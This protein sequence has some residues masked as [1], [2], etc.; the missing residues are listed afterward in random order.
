MEYS[1]KTL[2]LGDLHLKNIPGVPGYIKAQVEAIKR[3]VW[4]ESPYYTVLLGDVFHSR[5]PTPTE[6]LRF[7][8][9]IRE[10]EAGT[11]IK[12]FVI[13]GNHDSETKADDGVTCLSLFASEKT[14]VA[15][16][17]LK[18]N[19]F[20][21]IPH[22]EKQRTIEE[23]LSSIKNGFVFGHF[24]YDGA[25]NS[26]GDRDFS[27]KRHHFTRPTFLGHIHHEKKEG[28]IEV[29]GTPYTTSFS[30]A[31]KKNVYGILWESGPSWEF[32]RKEI[33]WGPRHVVVPYEELNQEFINDPDYFTMLR[34]F[35][36]ELQVTA[37]SKVRAEIKEKFNVK[38]IDIK[39]TPVQE[40]KDEAQSSFTVTQDV[41]E[42]TD[43][44]IEKYVAENNTKLP[45]DSIMAG[46]EELKDG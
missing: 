24:G 4:R 38:Y 10:I 2:V 31:G 12:V 37:D 36:N 41:F 19:N 42:V 21:F 14:W 34:V 28:T 22:Y 17:P 27:I 26:A 46:L 7:K 40:G 15:I 32:E 43:E 6:L 30:E 39:F 20:N 16:H 35:M 33:T 23:K 9:L 3:I 8:E 1:K 44:L 29:L 18:Y 11:G 45:T 5:K 13:R 25:T